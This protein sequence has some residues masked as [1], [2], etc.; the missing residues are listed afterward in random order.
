MLLYLNTIS[1]L[2]ETVLSLILSL[3]NF[4]KMVGHVHLY[5]VKS[6]MKYAFG[7]H[8]LNCLSKNLSHSHICLFTHY[9]DV[10]LTTVQS[11][12]GSSPKSAYGLVFKNNLSIF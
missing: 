12:L 5:N 9:L 7:K 3:L 1:I 8:A 6:Y 10:S 11:Q 4:Q 2:A